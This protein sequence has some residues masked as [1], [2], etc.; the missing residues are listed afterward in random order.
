[1]YPLPLFGKRPVPLGGE[2]QRVDDDE[3][4]N[5]TAARRCI[6][7]LSSIPIDTE[8]IFFRLFCKC[9]NFVKEKEIV[10]SYK[11]LFQYLSILF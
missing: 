9:K 4:E 6:K 8:D 1:M 2:K 10:V 11:K 7:H 5:H 3:D